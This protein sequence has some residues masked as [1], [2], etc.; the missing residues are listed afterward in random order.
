MLSLSCHQAV[1]AT[2]RNARNDFKNLQGAGASSGTYGAWSPWT[3]HE[4]PCW[5]IRAVLS[6][7][8]TALSY[9]HYLAARPWTSH[10]LNSLKLSSSVKIGCDD[11]GNINKLRKCLA[12]GKS[13]ECCLPSWGQR[14]WSRSLGARPGFNGEVWADTGA[15]PSGRTMLKLEATVDCQ[16]SQADRNHRSK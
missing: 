4:T 11:D 1:Q 16:N 14:G 8:K 15:F 12:D 10:S 9:N 7:N 5:P 2:A 13:R 3:S 6:N